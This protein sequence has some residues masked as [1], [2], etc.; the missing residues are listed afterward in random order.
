MGLRGI[1]NLFF[2]TVRLPDLE[3]HPHLSKVVK[4]SAVAQ[5]LEFRVFRLDNL[6]LG[7]ELR[8]RDLDLVEREPLSDAHSGAALEDGEFEFNFNRPLTKFGPVV[9]LNLI[10]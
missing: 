6:K 1:Y 10:L 4:H 5:H 8:R 9:Q 7:H 2:C 3:F